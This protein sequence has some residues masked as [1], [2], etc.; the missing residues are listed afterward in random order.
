MGGANQLGTK[1]T[2]QQE[3]GYLDWKAKNRPNDSGMDYDLRGAY[4]AQLNPDNRGH[5]DDEFKFPNHPTFSTGS[6]Y[7]TEKTPGGEWKKLPSGQFYFEPSRW[8][9]ND[10]ERMKFLLEYMKKAE[11]ES[12]LVRRPIP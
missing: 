1:L 4:L 5:L 8:M 9:E 2:P 12:V 11:P 3:A 7:S 10:T 6:K